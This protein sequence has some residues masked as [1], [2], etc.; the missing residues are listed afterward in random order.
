[1][2]LYLY[3][4]VAERDTLNIEPYQFPRDEKCCKEAVA[5]AR[6]LVCFRV[7]WYASVRCGTL[8]IA[9][10]PGGV[11]GFSRRPQ[12]GGMRLVIALAGSPLCFLREKQGSETLA[13]A[14]KRQF[15]PLA[16]TVAGPFVVAALARVL[17]ARPG[18]PLQEVG[19]AK[20]GE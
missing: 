10:S 15:W 2:A 19:P 5:A 13:P 9:S 14:C 8:S 4:D 16:R 18:R 1:M 6:L 7:F 12:R 3:V 11:T 20:D 17:P